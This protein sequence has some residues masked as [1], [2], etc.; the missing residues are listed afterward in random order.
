MVNP[1]RVVILE[2][3]PS[4]IKRLQEHLLTHPDIHLIAIANTTAQA[5]EAIRKHR[6]DLVFLDINIR[7]ESDDAGLRLARTVDGMTKP[8][9]IIFLSQYDHY[10]LN[11]SKCHPV[12][13]LSKPIDPGELAD[14]LQWVREH[15]EEPG[16]TGGNIYVWGKDDESGLSSY[17]G[18]SPAEI[19]Y[20]RSSKSQRNRMDMY[21]RENRVIT[22]IPSS[23]NK[24]AS[25]NQ[26]CPLFKVQKSHMVNL[27]QVRA[28]IRSG[29]LLRER[30]VELNGGASLTV[31]R[32]YWR[33]L[34][35]EVIK[36]SDPIL[37]NRIAG[38]ELHL[39]VSPI[40]YFLVE[41]GKVGIHLADGAV[42][43]GIGPTLKEFTEALREKGF[44]RIHE[45]CLLNL[46][47]HK[48]YGEIRQNQ[49]ETYELHLAGKPLPL[50]LSRRS[51]EA[52]SRALRDFLSQA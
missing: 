16:G 30:R 26:A 47:S 17:I 10:A 19:L 14:H 2:D 35:A 23:M 37:E 42:L 3:E 50:R 31:S 20:L 36:R 43:A 32:D 45:D 34:K 5:L 22:S 29:P 15:R 40:H 52:L 11:A 33:P 28:L 1:L 44:Y 38:K 24:F 27:D 21:R 41:N 25:N 49:D 46:L 51:V 18:V 7:T 39:P 12:V 13:F 9:H 48:Q 8:P 4:D 6:P